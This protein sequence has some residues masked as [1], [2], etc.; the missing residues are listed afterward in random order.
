MAPQPFV[1]VLAVRGVPDRGHLGAEPLE[2]LRGDPGIGA[3]GAVDRDPEA[4]EVGAE[5]LEHVVEVAVGVD[6][7]AVDRPAAAFGR[8]EQRLDLLLGRVGELAAVLVEE[9]DAVV[10]R[11]VVRSR[12]DDAEVER[13]Q[14]HGGRREHAG[15][16]GVPA[17][18]DDAAR[19]RLLELGA[20]AAGVTADE[21]AAAAG[22][23]RRRLAEPLDEVDGQILA[24]DATDAVGAEVPGGGG[25]GASA[26]YRLENCGALRAL[27]RPAFLRSTTRASRVRKPSRLSGTRSSGSASTSAR[28]IP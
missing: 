22:P 23:E 4:G 5:A 6:A 3:V 27:W 2:R 1:D 9:L 8:V 17:G 25:E 15:E 13:E 11:R 26:S 20:G 14:R 28:A 24:D 12:D 10:L 18:G 7:D 21:D 16:H 19:E